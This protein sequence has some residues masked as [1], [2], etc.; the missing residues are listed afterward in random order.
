MK[1]IRC[2]GKDEAAF[3]ASLRERS[4]APD[5]KVVE[6]V[7]GILE[8]VR[9]NGDAAVRAYTEKFDGKCPECFEVDSETISNAYHP[10]FLSKS[11]I[12]RTTAPASF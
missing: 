12:A 9:K 4:A 8:D 1:L 11:L 6:T 5:Q 10:F 7:T 2:N 3:F